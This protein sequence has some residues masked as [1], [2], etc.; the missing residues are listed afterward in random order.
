MPATIDDIQASLDELISTFKDV[1]DE[2]IDL[3]EKFR[4]KG[5][6]P[7]KE[8]EEEDNSLQALLGFSNF[9]AKRR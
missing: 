3:N 2:L 1:K 6:D 9:K 4:G 8:E 5:D 7:E